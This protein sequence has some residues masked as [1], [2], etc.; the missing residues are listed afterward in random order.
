MV[1][2]AS[3]SSVFSGKTFAGEKGIVTGWGATKEGGSISHSL[4]E[5]V[6]PILSNTE[7]RAT[8][9]PSRKITDNML[10]AGYKQGG[11]DSCQVRK[12]HWTSILFSTN[13]CYIYIIVNLKNHED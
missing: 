3:S 8:K 6:V 9:Y 5:V 1:N 10:C 7:C 11:K 2:Y 4:Q 13:T 12:S